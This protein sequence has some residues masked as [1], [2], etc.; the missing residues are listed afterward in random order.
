[1]PARQNPATLRFALPAVLAGI[2]AWGA[3]LP[4]GAAEA[5]P[6][7]LPEIHGFLQA[8]GAARLGSANCPAGTACDWPF[9]EQRLQ[10]KAE[11]GGFEGTLG[12]AG[13]IDLLHD[14]ALGESEV[15][16]RELYADYNAER[17]TVRAGRQVVTWG[18]ADLL[19][20][21][22]TFPKDW[23]AFYGGLPLEYLKRGSDAVRLDLFPEFA[24][25]QLVLA[26]FR[27]DRL[28]DRER[29][30]LP[31]QA[32]QAE[33]D[34]PSG[35]EV[36]LRVSRYVGS[37]DGALY[38]SH[39][40]YRAP[41][42]RQIGGQAGAGWQ[43]GFPRLNAVGASLSGPLGS[44]VLS[45]EAGYYDSVDDRDGDDPAIENSQ[46]RLLA[47]YSR[48]IGADTTLGLQ[49]YVEWMHDHAAYRS[50][51]PAGYPERDE[52]R[53]VATL[54]L[55]R[56]EMHQTLRLSLFAFWGISEGDGYLIPSARYA[57]SDA[58]W[59]EV[60]ANLIVG[61]RSGQFGVLG[62]NDNVYMTLR[63][64]F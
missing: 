27:P 31:G 40:H 12:Y 55:T 25:V 5:P 18:V 38:L 1:V 48:Q 9:N 44:G 42:I 41:A 36:G 57:F 16:V 19:F 29:F 35:L 32:I 21:N 62:D 61:D 28:P 10:L 64:A 63:Y 8:H 47:G 11:G 14:A 43:G 34:E 60:G 45:L 7:E 46:T 30:V 26:D 6:L 49:G 15:D 17:Y 37:W 54:R 2:L 20:I 59:G 56:F 13:K 22:D 58:L 23:T 53:S 39:T 33:L 3:G 4:A 50:T 52:L 24:D 51:L